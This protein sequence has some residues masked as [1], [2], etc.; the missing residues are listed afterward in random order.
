VINLLMSLEI[1]NINLLL[2]SANEGPIF[3]FT[4]KSAPYFLPEITLESRGCGLHLN[5][6]FCQNSKTGLKL[7]LFLSVWKLRWNTKHKFFK[8]LLNRA[9]LT[10][11]NEKILSDFGIIC[12]I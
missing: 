10:K 5:C 2:T 7:L 6:K 11:N 12:G 9:S 8:L 1:R 3:F 4:D